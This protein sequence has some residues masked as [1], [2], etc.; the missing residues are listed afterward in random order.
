MTN[1]VTG[2]WTGEYSYNI[3]KGIV[4][5]FHA[6]LEQHGALLDG[7]TT[8]NNAIDGQ[9]TQFLIA[10]LFGKVTGTAVNF[11]KTY[12]NG[13]PRQEKIHYEG[14]ISEDGSHINGT[15][16]ITN[17]WKGT[18]KMS[19][20]IEQKPRENVSAELADCLTKT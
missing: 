8:E 11:T 4:V 9:A 10:K 18:F 6:E 19:R 13:P 3:L 7:N 2:F 5:E 1:N 12:T 14:T 16:K 17:M 20:A 15:W